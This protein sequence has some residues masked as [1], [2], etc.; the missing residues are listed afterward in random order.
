MDNRLNI[1]LLNDIED[2]IKDMFSG[3]ELI[4]LTNEFAKSVGENVTIQVVGFNSKKDI[5]S[6]NISDMS[7]NA[8]IKF[9]DQLKTIERVSDNPKLVMKIDEL[10]A[11]KLPLIE[12]TRNNITNL[13]SDY[14]SNITTAWK[15]SVIFYNDQ[16]Y[17]GAL[18]SIRLTLELLLKKLLGNDKSLENQKAL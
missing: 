15:E 2:Q 16:K 9:F 11:S 3:N 5:L 17:R 8:K 13:L 14:S 1:M 18:D 12:N 7:D 6:K 4:T 10:I